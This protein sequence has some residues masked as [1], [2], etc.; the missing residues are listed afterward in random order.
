MQ[1]PA[2]LA[3]FP[4]SAT[5]RRPAP[6][7]PAAAVFLPKE[8]GSWSLAL[9]PLALG[10]L[11]A[12]SSAGGAL[13]VAA[14]AGFFAR[15]PFKALFSPVAARPRTAALAVLIFSV[16]ALAG[17]SLVLV[18]G[19]IAPLWPLLLAAPLGGLFAWF[20][21]QNGSRAAAAEVAGSAAFALVP[22]ALAT[23]AGWSAGPALALAALA[24]TRSVPTVLS[25]RSSLRQAKGETAGFLLPVLATVAAA[26]GVSLMGALQL[27]PIW[28]AVP[29]WALLARTLW[30]A[31]PFR[32]AW[33]ARRIGMFETITGLLYVA[34]ITAAYRG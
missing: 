8:H 19:G 32:P 26:L 7:A 27:V 13:T 31:S 12:P 14:L 11:V 21:A 10:L 28:T 23:L 1:G 5:T 30:F 20:D 3:S 24:L 34:A 16:L 33:P 2:L 18:P 15:R 29:A 4:G 9:E 6:A 25:V 22:A 17:F